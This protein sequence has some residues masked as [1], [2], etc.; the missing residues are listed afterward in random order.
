MVRDRLFRG[1]PTLAVRAP[2]AAQVPTTT[3][4]DQLTAEIAP[5]QTEEV[6]AIETEAAS[7]KVTE[8]TT[9]PTATLPPTST[10]TSTLTSTP[11]GDL[12][13]FLYNQF[14]FYMVN[15]SGSPVDLRRIAFRAVGSTTFMMD[16]RYLGN[17]VPQY[18]LGNLDCVAAEIL[19]SRASDFRFPECQYFN[20]LRTPTGDSAEVFW[21]PRESIAQFSV[22]WNLKEVA[23]CEIAAERCEVYLP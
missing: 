9:Q 7:L 8:N 2:S 18:Q 23:Q 13:L 20:Y 21:I 12:V 3:Q 14:G 11:S 10:P 17:R 6:G 19:G 4:V 22:I 16:G 5:S 1:R 15:R